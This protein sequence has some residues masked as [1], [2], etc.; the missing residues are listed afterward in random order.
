MINLKTILVMAAA[1]LFSG[2]SGQS[3]VAQNFPEEQ[4]YRPNYHFTPQNGW[5]NDPNGLFYLDGTYHLFFQHYPDGNKWGP[6]HWGHA[7]SKDLVKWEEQPVALAP[8]QLGY[9][10]SGSA[11][12]DKDNTSGFGDGKNIPVVAA[13]T[14]HNTEKEKS[15]DIDVESQALA[16]SLD[17]GKTWTKYSGNPVLKNPGIRDFRDPKIFRDE[18]RQQWV[19]VLAAQDRAHFYASKNLKDWAFLSD[20]G[21]DVGGHGGVW[22]CPDLFPLKVQG[23]NEEKWVLIININPGGPNGG[24]AA[25][26]F[27][28]DFDGKTFRTDEVFTRQLQKEKALWMDWGRDNYAS[29][30]FDNVPHDKRIII[31]WMSNWDYAQDVPTDQWRSSATIP[32]KMKLKK[33]AEGYTLLNF[34]VEQLSHY[35][36]KSV[37]KKEILN[38][39]KILLKEGELDLAKTVLNISLN[40]LK[41]GTYTFSAY[42]KNGEKITFGLNN[43]EHYLFADR[44]TSGKTDFKDNFAD[45]ISKAPLAGAYKNASFK[46]LL[47]KTS[48]EIFMDNGEKVLTEIFFPNHPFTEFSVSSDVPG[49]SLVMDACQ[50]NIK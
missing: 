10:F 18:K 39:P 26:Y 28:G 32:R 25:Q 19:M 6:M 41:A 24:S 2:C 21:K 43:K 38:A 33:T 3:S 37:Q 17:K 34:P 11:V 46:I 14:Y 15:G 4:L 20:F 9:I 29:V 31:G 5:M 40:D 27:V 1:S 13:F 36:G 48:L 49:T 50:L 47:D 35:K 45:R 30:S 22:E 16:Y 7:T 42:N 12:V 44:R 8:D 23:T